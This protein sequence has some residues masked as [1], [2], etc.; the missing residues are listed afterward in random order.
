MLLPNSLVFALIPIA[1]VTLAV[2]TVAFSLSTFVLS[3]SANHP[4]G[5]LQ[6]PPDAGAGFVPTSPHTAHPTCPFLLY[7]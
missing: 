6:R 4:I 7:L 5:A 2:A 1:L 3:P